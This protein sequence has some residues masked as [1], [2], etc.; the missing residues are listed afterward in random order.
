MAK[1]VRI[2]DSDVA[3]AVGRAASGREAVML[4]SALEI[5][6]RSSSGSSVSLDYIERALDSLVEFYVSNGAVRKIVASFE[7]LYDEQAT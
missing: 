3:K 5:A 1:M 7:A 6:I 2:T 4:R